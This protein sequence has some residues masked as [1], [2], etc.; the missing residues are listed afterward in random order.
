MGDTIDFFPIRVEQA[1][2]QSNGEL[3]TRIR[4]T[5]FVD[6]QGVPVALELDELDSAA[7]HWI[8]WGEND[9]PMGVAR[10]VGNKIGRMAVL[11]EYRRQ[12]VGSALLRAII[13]HAVESG[14]ETLVLDAQLHAAGF[15]EDNGFQVCGDEF[16]DAG[17]AHVPMVMDLQRFIHRRVTP[18]PPDIDEE[19]RHRHTIDGVDAYRDAALDVARHSDRTLRILSRELDPQVFDRDDFCH[20]VFKLV[21]NH[22]QSKVLILVKDTAWLGRHFHRLVESFQRLTSHIELRRQNPEI[23]TVHQEFITGDVNGVLYCQNP[24]HY[25]GFLCLH[26]PLEARQLNDDFDVLW[27]Q[28]QPDPSIRKLHI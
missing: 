23:D 6:E 27:D 25:T 21:T 24:R 13:N 1:D 7:T 28:S 20:A 5:V 26:A 22:P 2:W 18:P 9:Q 14:I 19:L 3:L 12:G 10:L 15:Y 8:A 16:P 17:I 11:A 4:A